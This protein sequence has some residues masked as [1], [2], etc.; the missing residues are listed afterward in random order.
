MPYIAASLRRHIDAQ[1]NFV[2][3]EGKTAGEMNYI[4]STLVAKWVEQNGARR[5]DNL[6]QGHSVLQDAAAEYY[7]RVMAPYEDEA[8]D[9]HGDVYGSLVSGEN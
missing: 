9:K 4:L 7:R 3:V 2:S 5:Y 8:M 6:R 1:L